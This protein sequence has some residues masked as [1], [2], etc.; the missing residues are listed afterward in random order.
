[1]AQRVRGHRSDQDVLGQQGGVVLGQGRRRQGGQGHD[2][3]PSHLHV[4]LLAPRGLVLER[5]HGRLSS[6]GAAGVSYETPDP[7]FNVV[8]FAI[9]PPGGPSCAIHR[10]PLTPLRL[11]SVETWRLKLPFAGADPFCSEPITAPLALVS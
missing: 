1:G 10:P 2:H 5:A 11:K 8:T 9:K 3:Q 6:R 7:K 4:L